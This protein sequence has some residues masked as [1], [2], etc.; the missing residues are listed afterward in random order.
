[1]LV[2]DAEGTY[3]DMMNSTTTLE[4]EKMRTHRQCYE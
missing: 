2:K 4:Y 3:A 1:M